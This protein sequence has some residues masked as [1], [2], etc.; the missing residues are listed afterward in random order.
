[1]NDIKQ[2]I[3]ALKEKAVMA[4]KSF[5]G[6]NL[7][8]VDDANKLIE[9]LESELSKSR[10]RVHE[11][12]ALAKSGRTKGITGAHELQVLLTDARQEERALVIKELSEREVAKSASVKLKITD[13]LVELMSMVDSLSFANLNLSLD[14]DRLVVTELAATL[15]AKRY[16][17]LRILGVAPNETKQLSEVTV[18]RFQSLDEFC[19]KDLAAYP[20]RGEYRHEHS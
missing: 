1:M 16:Q 10:T 14:K 19:D 9:H 3:D 12:Q 8:L 5:N 2:Q 20:D 11:L 4:R 13:K 18:I 15:D 6:G 17:R 7:D